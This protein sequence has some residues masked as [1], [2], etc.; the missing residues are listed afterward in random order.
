MKIYILKTLTAVVMM[1]VTLFTPSILNAQSAEKKAAALL[2]EVTAKMKAYK[3]MKLEF[4][5]SMT[6]KTQRINESFK[7]TILSKGEK[8]RLNISEQQIFCDGKTV[9]TYQKDA[10]EVQISE[11]SGDEDSFTPTKFMT[12]YSKNYKSKLIADKGN[13]LVI[14]M[15]PVKGRKKFSKVNL[16]LNKETK[17]V[18]SMQVFDKNGAVFTYNIENFITNQPISDAEFV[19]KASN[20]PKV[21]VVD[22]R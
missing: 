20:Y 10:N 18:K 19:F 11:V 15:A 7:G 4:T 9:W 8:Y 6:N 12:S 3:T 17:Q 1:T 13:V 5:Y 2:D 14:E 16:T 21:E 22:M